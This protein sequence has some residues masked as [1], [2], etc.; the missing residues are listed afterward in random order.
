MESVMNLSDCNAPKLVICE[1]LPAVSPLQENM[2]AK[3]DEQGSP[4]RKTA[5]MG[6]VQLLL[7]M[8]LTTTQ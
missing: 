5:L 1:S 6:Q 2:S 3:E 8:H 4:R 7:E